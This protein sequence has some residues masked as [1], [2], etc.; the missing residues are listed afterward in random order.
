[1][2]IFTNTQ[3]AKSAAL[4]PN[5]SGINAEPLTEDNKQEALM[6]LSLHPVNTVILSG[7]IR[8][9]G[10]V[11]PKHRGT[12]YGCR[13]DNGDLTGVAIIGPNLLFEA[14]TDDA[15]GAFAQCARECPDVRMIFAK[16][17]EL[18]IFWRHYR[19]EVE[20]PE[21][22][23]Q[24]LIRSGGP[25]SSNVEIINELRIANADDLDQI[26]SAHAEMVFAETGVDPLATDADGFRTRCAARVDVGRVWV[27]MKEGELVVKTDIIG[28]T[29]E[30]VYLEGLWVNPKE[31]GKRISTRCMAS[32]SE[33]FTK[34]SKTV[35]G[36]VDADHVL[37]DSL[38]RNAG[39]TDFAEYA[40]VYV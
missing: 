24:R 1:M 29:P 35:C 3:Y 18:D 27:W 14:T 39:F 33:M 10:I 22:S 11:S 26:V 16:K 7:W 37:A 30:A 13:N 4:Y 40:K 25:I 38:Y 31:R 17:E 34:E 15:V 28:D 36:F 12:Y 6:F 9:H 8:D 5:N 21:P 19:P 2:N 32:L 23:T 20:M